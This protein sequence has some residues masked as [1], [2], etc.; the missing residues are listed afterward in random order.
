MIQDSR[1]RHL[2]VAPE[3]DG[4]YVFYW[5]QA[6]Q[7]TRMNHALTYAIRAA[8]D[9]QLPLLIGFGLT[10]D[11]PEANAR[12]YA[13][14]LEGLRDVKASAEKRGIGFVV[15]KGSPDD[16]AIGLADKAALTVTDRGYLRIQRQW[17][18]K[19]ARS[20]PCALIEVE[21]E[22]V[23]PV[24]VASDKEEY[25]AR[26]IRPKIHRALPDYLK[27]LTETRIKRDFDGSVKGD[28]DLSD[29]DAALASLSV[30]RSVA[31]VSTYEGGEVEACRRLRAFIDEK[32]AGYDADRNDPNLEGV[33]NMSPYLHF[34]Q[35]SV[36]DIA[37]AVKDAAGDAGSENVDAYLEE[38]IVRREL[39]VNFCTHNPDYDRYDCLPDWAQATLDKHRDDKREYFYTRDQLEQAETHDPYWNAAQV[40][41]TDTGKMHNYMRM[42]WG[43]KIIEWSETPEE[44]FE[45][46]LYLNNKYELDG[47]D[48]NS[49]TGVAWCFGKHDRPWQERDIFGTVRYMNANG[50]K[51]K[52]DRDGYV[53]KVAKATGRTLSD[54]GSLF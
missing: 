7:R 53:E 2:N 40:E 26:T 27:P 32:L 39:S 45:T 4:D 18:E 33:S 15:R 1:V 43:K 13:F 21:S 54:Q 34:G 49:F 42:Y 41:M 12:H 6:S 44:A 11:Y 17:R 10:D 8:N 48:V 38:L 30:D 23:V 46:T 20:I 14:M 31:R 35:V 24:D 9:R 52:F 36:L 37:L 25:A 47:R 29:V 3:R 51:R 5:M 19:V 50:L 22:T 16:V 28:V